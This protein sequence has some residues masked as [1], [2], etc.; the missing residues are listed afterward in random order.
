MRD[1]TE[2]IDAHMHL[3]THKLSRHVEQKLD[4]LSPRA[5]EAARIWK[6]GF[7]RKY[8]SEIL[9]DNRDSPARIAADWAAELDRH[10]VDKACFLALYPG[11][12]EL[13]E[14]LAAGQGRFFGLATVD[15]H[16]PGAPELLR[17]RVAEEHYLGL[18]LYPPTQYFLPSDRVLYPLYEEARGLGI[19]V[20]FH[21]GITLSFEADLRYANP[22]ELHPVAR[23]FPDLP[24][25]VPHFGSGYLKELFFLAYHVH[26][27]Y[28]E[29]S[30]RNIWTEYL[31]YPLTLRDAFKKGL[32]I[33]GPERIIFG[34]DSR[35]LSRGYRRDVLDT[36]LAIL[37]ELG[38]GREEAALIMG[39]NIRRLLK[40]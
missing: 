5:R 15:P 30:G 34:S 7:I 17:R 25:V 2:I 37:T 33:F 32:E 24:L 39:G 40:I 4:A 14:F 19:P 10:G 38:V 28:L 11:E 35:M 27:L 23:D 16:D 20:V 29:T 3:Y 36:Q 12:D 31:P 8:N 9:E 18:K 22:L 1:G 6:E 21:L 13:S 26:N